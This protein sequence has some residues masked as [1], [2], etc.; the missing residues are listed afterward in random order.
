MSTTLVGG[1]LESKEDTNHD[2]SESDFTFKNA[3]LNDLKLYGSYE[4]IVNSSET[5][6]LFLYRNHPPTTI[7]L[8]LLS[9]QDLP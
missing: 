5:R 7:M 9:L 6:R 4:V 1:R 3:I 2:N 8:N